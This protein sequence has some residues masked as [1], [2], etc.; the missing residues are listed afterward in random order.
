M[1]AWRIVAIVG[2]ASAFALTASNCAAAG[3]ATN[4]IRVSVSPIASCSVSATPLVF[5]VPLPANSTFDSTALLSLKCPPD[6]AFV[7]EID[8]GLNA[9]GNNRRVFNAAA[10]AYLTYDV[11]KDP[12]KS[13]V[14]GKGNLKN[15]SGNSGLTG[16]ALYT[17][18]GRLTGKSSMKAGGYRD[19][20]T[21][22]VTF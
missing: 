18:Y 4:Q 14:W 21:I 13:Q 11:Y 20:L 5:F 16:L 22:T 8:N 1:R 9:Q 3:R 7:I 17:V 10:N 15:V 19:T 12:P 2:A 6:T